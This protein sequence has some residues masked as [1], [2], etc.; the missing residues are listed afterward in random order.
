MSDRPDTTAGRTLADIRRR[1]EALA[2]P[3]GRY[4]LVCAR[5]GGRPFPAETLRFRDREAALEAA[6]TAS[7]YRAR[8]RTWD[9]RLPFREFVVRAADHSEGPVRS[10]TEA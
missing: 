5:T 7:A 10:A 4:Y 9:E 8:L 1:L 6:E 3:S 2:D